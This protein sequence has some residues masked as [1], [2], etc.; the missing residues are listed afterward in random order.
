MTILSTTHGA[1]N[2][3]EENLT[4]CAGPAATGDTG[5]PHYHESPRGAGVGGGK[6]KAVHVRIFTVS[7]HACDAF[8]VLSVFEDVRY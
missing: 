2:E 3:N 7:I 6:A 8:A 4:L 1:N 5:G